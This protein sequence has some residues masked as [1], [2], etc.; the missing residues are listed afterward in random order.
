DDELIG[1]VEADVLHVDVDA[2]RLRLAQEGR[3][4]DAAR[5]ARAKVGQQPLQGQARVDDVL[6]D[7][8]VAPGDITGEILEDAHHAG[9]LRA[10]AVGGDR[11]PVHLDLQVDLAGEVGHHHD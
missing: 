1:D 3:D 7:Q 11:H 8:H 9:G 6:D 4:L 10:G 2:R 5:A